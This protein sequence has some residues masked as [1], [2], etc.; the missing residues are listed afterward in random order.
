MGK[1]KKKH[2]IIIY[3]F[4]FWREL[5]DVVGPT[6]RLFYDFQK[7]SEKENIIVKG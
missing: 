6:K 2:T 1:V 5:R 3:K 4:K 7:S